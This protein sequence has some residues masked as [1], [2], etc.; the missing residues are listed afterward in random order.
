[1]LPKNRRIQRVYF[2]TLLNSNKKFN[3]EHLTLFLHNKK[4]GSPT[5]FSFSISK[6]NC[7]SAVLRNKF[8]RRSY[9]VISKNI[10]NIKPNFM[11]FF[12]FKKGFNKLSYFDL[13]KQILNLLQDSLVLI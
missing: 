11:C 3:S 10:K 9:S 4:D 6:K 12:V 5:V 7:K 2:K 1:M 13:E 8:R